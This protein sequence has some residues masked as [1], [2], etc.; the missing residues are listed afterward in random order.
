MND[1]N[2]I[3]NTGLFIIICV[4]LFACVLT[5]I[6]VL[7]VDKYEHTNIN[8][9]VRTIEQEFVRKGFAYYDE[10]HNFRLFDFKNLNNLK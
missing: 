1:G 4:M 9:A 3:I 5:N 10:F 7:T 8:N 2:S 6:N